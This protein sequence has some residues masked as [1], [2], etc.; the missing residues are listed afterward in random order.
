MRTHSRHTRKRT[1]RRAATR[2]RRLPPKSPLLCLPGLSRNGADF[3]GLARALFPYPAV[4]LDLMGRGLADRCANPDRYAPP[5]LLDDIHHATAALGLHRAIGVGT[6]FGG[7]LGI[8]LAISQPGLL[9]GSIINDV[10]RMR[11]PVVRASGWILSANHLRHLT[12]HRQ[13]PIC[14]A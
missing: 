8:A 2:P 3:A 4:A 6:S 9:A 11:R 14:K 1:I 10:A 5:R 13:S 12:G 7:L